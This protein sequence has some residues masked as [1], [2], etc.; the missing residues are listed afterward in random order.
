MHA[1]RPVLQ[2]LVVD[3][4]RDAADAMVMAAQVLGHEA[5]AVYDGG[6]ALELLDSYRPDLMILDLSMPGM[7]GYALAAAIRE[8]KEFEATPL[9]AL[10]GFGA[11]ADRQRALQSGFDLHTLKPM[12]IDTLEQL[13]L[14]VQRAPGR[15]FV[16]T[17]QPRTGG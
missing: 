11:D 6:A 12:E 10:S 4:N 17:Q 5:V 15:G 3:D 9:V 16:S 7:D 2:L 13:L 14:G 1:S 8:R